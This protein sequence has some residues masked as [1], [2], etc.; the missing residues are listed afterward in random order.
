[1]YFPHLFLKQLGVNWKANNL[2][3]S[4]K[5]KSTV[6]RIFMKVSETN[7]NSRKIWESKNMRESVPLLVSDFLLFK[8]FVSKFNKKAQS[9]NVPNFGV[10][11]PVSWAPVYWVLSPGS[12]VLD[13]KS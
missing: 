3:K 4:L 1:M 12:R 5:Q 13:P 6:A 7:R 11:S 9:P 2:D 8:V 10:L